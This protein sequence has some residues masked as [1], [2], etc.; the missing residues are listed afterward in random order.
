MGKKAVV[1]LSG[2]MDST[3]TL[4]IAKKEGFEIYALS[5]DYGQRNYLEIKK[6]EK[7]AEFFG[8]K[9]HLVI[10][11]H[12]KK[13]GGSSLTSEGISLPRGRDL[14]E[15]GKEI[16]S[17]YVPARNTIFLSY[18]LAWAEVLG[19]ED[20]FIGVNAIDCSGYPDTRP[21]YIHAFEQMAKL[22]TKAGVEG[23]LKFKIRIPLIN[24]S[25]AEII[26]KGMALGV[27]YS[28]THSCYDPFPNGMAC[29]DCDSCRLRLKGFEEAGFKDPISYKVIH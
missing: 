27:D 9:D 18:A 23:K 28:L 19:A 22:A 21:E 10:P 14:V 15:I 4:A 13:I 24:L 17:T 11:V 25:K 7:V 20:I 29:G 1:L 2:G 8:A 16:P 5:F 3:T 6:A 26:K 12:L